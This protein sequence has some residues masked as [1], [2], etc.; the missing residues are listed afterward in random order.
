M[1][2]AASEKPEALADSWWEPVATQAK[3]KRPS[4]PEV[5]CRDP[6]EMVAPGMRAWVVSRTMPAMGAPLQAAGASV[7]A[8]AGAGFGAYES[9][10]AVRAAAM[11]DFMG[12]RGLRQFLASVRQ[13]IQGAV[14]G[15]GQI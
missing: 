2:S 9:A 1:V 3:W 7:R 8:C 14:M 4:E 6:R 5:V 12:P 15:L 13:L 11:V 10:S